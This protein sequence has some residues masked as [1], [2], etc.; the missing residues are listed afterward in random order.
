MSA[1]PPAKPGSILWHDLTV[2]N[3]E[4]VRDFYAAVVGWAP[5]PVDMGGYSDFNMND[6]DGACQAGVCH[7]RGSNEHIPA[8][9]MMY[10]KVADL[11]AAVKRVSELGGEMIGE[12]R[13]KPGSRYCAIRDPAGAV[14]SITE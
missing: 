2:P 8:Q 11:D 9:W 1:E 12:V 3:A 14:L 5:E 13:G 4:S 6:A 10:V 7:N